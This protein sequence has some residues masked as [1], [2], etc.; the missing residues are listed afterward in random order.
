MTT[1]EHETMILMFARM[2]QAIGALAN[3]LKSREIMT[4]DDLKAFLYDAWA[5]DKQTLTFVNQAQSDYRK[6]AQLSGVEGLSKI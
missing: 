4:A 1:Q 2:Y 6:A 5:D 3:V